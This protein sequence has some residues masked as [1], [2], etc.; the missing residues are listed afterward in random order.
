MPFCCCCFVSLEP[1]KFYHASVQLIEYPTAWISG[2]RV[3]ITWNPNELADQP[4]T[5]DIINIVYHLA[6]I[7]VDSNITVVSEQGNTGKAEF[8]LPELDNSR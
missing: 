5:V 4:I 7:Q 2:S 8:D 1:I 3:H 6:T